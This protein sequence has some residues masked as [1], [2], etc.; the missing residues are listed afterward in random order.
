M[1]AARAGEGI[2]DALIDHPDQGFAV[3]PH[4]AKGA[5][6]G[7]YAVLRQLVGLGAPD[8]EQRRRLHDGD[9]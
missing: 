1:Y 9:E 8:T 5:I 4:G 6:D 2:R 3:Y 7:Q